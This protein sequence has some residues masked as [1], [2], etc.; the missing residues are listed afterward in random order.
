MSNCPN[1][2]FDAGRKAD[3]NGVIDNWSCHED[4]S[5][6]KLW[7]P[8][9][10]T[11]VGSNAFSGC[12]NLVEIQF[13]DGGTQP[14]SLGLMSF[15][16][17]ASLSSLVLPA[18]TVS[19]GKGCF[20][21]CVALEAIEIGEGVEQLRVADHLFDNCAE[22]V[23]L[24]ETVAG[25]VER[26][27][28]LHPRAVPATNGRGAKHVNVVLQ[29]LRLRM[30]NGQMDPVVISRGLES[31]YGTMSTDSDFGFASYVRSY[32]EA[33]EY[34]SSV[35]DWS[36]A[37]DGDLRKVMVGRFIKK[38]AAL[39][40][41]EVK[42]A[43]F[44]AASKD[45]FRAICN[46]IHK[47]IGDDSENG[48]VAEWEDAYT[49]QF[50]IR[51]SAAFYRMIAA[52]KPDLVVQVPA[53]AKLAPVYAWLTGSDIE[54]AYNTGWY[55]LSRSVRTKLQELLP[56]KSLYQVGVFSWF[57]AEA[58]RD[59]LGSRDDARRRKEKVLNALRGAGLL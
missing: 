45:V 11:S 41:G 20:R 26:R 21:D 24:E 30:P 46:A 49:G 18:R 14:L 7:I 44:Q 23:A 56:G 57:L 54:D 4:L 5:V 53:I 16:R 38:V 36:E 40:W 17:C 8:N 37:S 12:A 28:A 42:E 39:N 9:T 59:D 34:F 35:G 25:E 22:K 19:I 50:T 32:G 10:V 27:E 47:L 33:C 2:Y 29:G 31:V 52:I 55:K 15:A 3:A 58:F 13:E 48:S 43:E 6:S 51:R 1:D